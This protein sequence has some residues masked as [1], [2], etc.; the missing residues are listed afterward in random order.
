MREATNHATRRVSLAADPNQ[1]TVESHTLR[2][3]KG[4]SIDVFSTESDVPK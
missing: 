3:G 2:D 1:E 4:Q